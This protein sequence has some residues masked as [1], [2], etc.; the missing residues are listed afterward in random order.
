MSALT[1]ASDSTVASEHSPTAYEKQF[2]YNGITGDSDCPELIY[3]SDYHTT[4][5]A[6]PT[7]RFG[8]VPVKSVHGVFDTPLNAVWGTVGPQIRDIVKAHGVKYS[9]IDTARFYTHGP[10]GEE[11]KGSLGPVVVWIGVRPGSTSADT[12]HDV[13]LVILTL[14]EKNKVTGVVV[15]W[16]E[17]VVQRLAGPPLLR[18]TDTTDATFRVRRFLTN[19]LAIPI[20]TASNEKDDAQGTT[21]MFFHPTGDESGKVYGLTNCHVFRENPTVDYELEEE[22]LEDHVRVCGMHRFQRGLAEIMKATADAVYDGQI[23]AGDLVRHQATNDQSKMGL[24]KTERLEATLKRK[25]EDIAVLEDFHAD[26]TNNW[27]NISLQRNIGH[28]VYAP[29]IKVDE[30]DTRY[31]ADWG[32]FEVSKAKCSDGFEG[33]VVFLGA[34]R[35]S[36]L[37]LLS[38]DESNPYSGTKYTAAQLRDMFSRGSTPFEYLDD[39]TL[40]V[41]DCAS[42]LSLSMPGERDAA[43]RCCLAVGKDG[44]TTD[45]TV[46]RYSGLESYFQTDLGVESIEIAIYN[47]GYNAVEPFSAK[48]DSGALVWYVVGNEARIV[49]QLHSGVNKGGPSGIYVTYCTPGW[50]LLEQIEKKYPHAN[51]FG[52]SW[53][54]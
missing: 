32:V 53:E 41:T 16:R 54:A 8:Q 33:N 7:G 39:G 6:K 19:L 38:S 31:T 1:L 47:S 42:K 21:T 11:E 12:A 29:A 26:V 34:F 4:P 30:A 17:A 2:Y 44:N 50:W 14:L 5:F 46:G 20:T 9:S 25:N 36:F 13:S 18:S 48:G 23:A 52:E 35:F 43:G 45:F 10:P 3:R 28:V 37:A 15:E 22:E 51:F 49:G 27:S 24:R 40:R